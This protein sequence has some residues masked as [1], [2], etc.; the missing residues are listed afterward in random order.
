[1]NVLKQKEI[2]LPTSLPVISSSVITGARTRKTD[3]RAMEVAWGNIT[4]GT[5]PQRS[6]KKWYE[7]INPTTAAEITVHERMADCKGVP[8]YRVDMKTK[9]NRAAGSRGS[10]VE[11]SRITN[12]FCILCKKWLCDPQLAAN[13]R[14]LDPHGQTGNG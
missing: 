13:R 10:C 11:C 14:I 3:T 1:M 7:R 4:A 6:V 5:T 2:L 12:I 8:I 9:N